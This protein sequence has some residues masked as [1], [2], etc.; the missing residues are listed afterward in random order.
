MAHQ[1]SEASQRLISALIRTI[2]LDKVLARYVK[3]AD[4]D[5]SFPRLPHA[6]T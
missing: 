1:D 5:R 6:H 3:R 4:S 2:G